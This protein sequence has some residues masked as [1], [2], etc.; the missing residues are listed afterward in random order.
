[1]KTDFNQNLT[2][3]R[4]VFANGQSEVNIREILQGIL[5]KRKWFFITTGI[6]SRVILSTVQARIFNPVYRVPTTLYDR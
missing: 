3:F 1:M 4:G 2:N 6:C 5:R